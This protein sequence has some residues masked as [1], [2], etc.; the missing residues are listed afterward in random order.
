MTRLL[1]GFVDELVK[2]SA[3]TTQPLETEPYNTTS[4][5]TKAMDQYQGA[6]AKVGLKTGNPIP[7]Y[8]PPKKMAGPLT[9]P[10]QLLGN[11]SGREA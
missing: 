2:L 3:F 10:T 11:W 6:R 7:S 9:T 8:P 1:H 4:P 5:A